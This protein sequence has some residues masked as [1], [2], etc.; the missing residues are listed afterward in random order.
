MIKIS[1]TPTEGYKYTPISQRDEEK[2]FSVFIKPLTTKQVMLLEDK[3][4]KRSGDSDIM[5]S[6]G[7][8]SFNTCKLGIT[9]WENI[10]DNE[11]NTLKLKLNVDGSIND[12]SLSYIPSELITEIA[13]V[14]IT[15]SRD[16]S[17]ISTFFGED[18]KEEPKVPK[19][20]GK[21]E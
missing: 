15:I 8:F 16:S 2:A 6:T 4:V 3:L 18:V 20:K 5:F 19:G 14:I 10:E 12:E 7:E 9:A 13:N 21:A 11:D 1:K 17:K